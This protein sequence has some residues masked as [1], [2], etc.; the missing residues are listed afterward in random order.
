MAAFLRMLVSAAVACAAVRAM[1][2]APEGPVGSPSPDAR[3]PIEA[4]Q[5]LSEA[6]LKRFYLGCA[7]AS[8]RN[9]LA[10][11]EI[12]LCSV[13]YERLL[14]DIFGGD[15]RAFLEWRRGARRP[16]EEAPAPAR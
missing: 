5:Q 10:G 13:G 12:A 11:G 16:P 15:F 8:V 6:D 9:Q 2:V 1:A 3:N 14:Q 4:I 7:R